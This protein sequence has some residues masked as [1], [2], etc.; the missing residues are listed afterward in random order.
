MQDNANQATDT[1]EN[2]TSIFS[3]DEFSMQGYDKHIKQAR[4]SL[5]AIAIL[6]FISVGVLYFTNKDYAEYI[7]I[8]LLIYGGFIAGFVA[9]GIWTKHKPYTAII[10]GLVLF[11]LFILLNAVIDPTTIIKGI[12][13]KVIVIV[14]LIKGLNDAKAAQAMKESFKK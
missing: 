4:N 10:C 12:I 11:G 3:E 5:Y 13:F 7:W 8:D 6:L 9:L 1:N 14:L 2:E